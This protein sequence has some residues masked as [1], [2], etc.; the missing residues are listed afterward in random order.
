MAGNKVD[1]EQI[2]VREWLKRTAEAAMA[3]P[4]AVPNGVLYQSRLPVVAP[5]YF[6]VNMPTGTTAVDLLAANVRWSPTL[7]QASVP[8]DVPNPKVGLIFY[9]L[10]LEVLTTDRQNIDAGTA[11]GWLP[12]GVRRALE[13]LYLAHGPNGAGVR[14]IPAT[15]IMTGPWAAPF[16]YAG[17]IDAG[18]P[19]SAVQVTGAVQA[20]TRY[21]AVP[22]G[23]LIVDA[24]SD[25]LEWRQDRDVSSYGAAGSV[26]IL[27]LS[28]LVIATTF[29][30]IQQRPDLAGDCGARNRAQNNA[31][32][33]ASAAFL[34]SI[35][36]G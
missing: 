6:E 24:N 8:N 28:G 2:T 7:V 11:T 9:G 32:Q 19:A 21:R 27:A 13:T 22:G 12:I 16:G 1:D 14:Y 36:K 18:D 26:P 15:D 35:F 20:G 30:A 4:L 23:A 5:I 3:P 31:D 25:T 29:P 17:E 33:L 34:D 10:K